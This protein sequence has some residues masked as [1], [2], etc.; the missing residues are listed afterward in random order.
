MRVAIV[1]DHAG[2]RAVLREVLTRQPGVE[3]VGE[4][5]DGDEV[6]A[7]VDA[8]G[9][10]LVVMDYRMR[11]VDGLSATH[12]LKA[13]RPSVEVAAVTSTADPTV[14]ALLLAA[15]ASCHFEKSRI[16]GLVEYLAARAMERRGDG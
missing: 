9:P 10:D 1:D 6:L 13:A 14:V 11:R 2:V 8:A 4:A 15:G 16:D 5:S 12:Q 7:M 3:V